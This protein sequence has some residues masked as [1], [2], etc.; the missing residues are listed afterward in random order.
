MRATN[1]ACGSARRGACSMTACARLGHSAHQACAAQVGAA[2]HKAESCW[3]GFQVSVV[4]ASFW[5]RNLS[6]RA[7][8]RLTCI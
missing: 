7:H 1:K 5:R 6:P 2:L 8:S 4:N 3:R